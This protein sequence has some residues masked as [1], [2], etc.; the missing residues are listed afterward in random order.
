MILKW[1]EW[2]KNWI[3]NFV[4]DRMPDGFQ[5]NRDTDKV[6]LI[7]R[8]YFDLIGLPPTPEEV[9]SFVND[10]SKD[11]FEKVVDHL[12][13]SPHFGERIAIYWLDLVR[14]A[15]TVG[16]H[17][18]QDHSIT[19]YRDWVIDALNDNMRFDQFTREQLAGDLLDN[20]TIDQK[21]ASGYNRL[22]QTTHEGGAQAREY[23]AIYAA[24]RVRNVSAVWMGATVGC[25]Q[26][27]DHKYDPY[28]IDDFYK[29]SA[30]F[31]DLDDAQHLSNGTNA[32][33]T[34]RDPEITV[35]SRRD[36]Q[37]VDRLEKE[38]EQ[39]KSR[40]EKSR[41]E[42]V[43]N[44]AEL[45]LEIKKLEQSI[46]EVNARQRKTMISAALKEPRTTRILPRGN[47]LDDSGP[48]VDPAIPGILGSISTKQNRPT[49][50]D[51]ANWLTDSEKGY[52]KLAARVMAN[53]FWYLLTG[54]A[55]S[56]TMDD[57]GG[58]GTPP[59]APDLLDNLAIEFVES[60]WDMKHLIRL[61]VTSRTYR[62]SS[63]ATAEQLKLDSENQWFA[64]AGRYRLPAEVI[65]DNALA[66]SGLLVD[67][68][69]G[70]SAKP[71]QPPGHYRHLNFPPRKYQR[72]TDQQQYRRGVYVHWQR[73]FLHPMLKSLDAPTREECSAERSRSN[74][75]LAALTLLN[76]PSF[77]EAARVFADRILT[78]GGEDFE[79]RLAFACQ[80]TLSR[81]PTNREVK[82][83]TQLF[84]ENKTVFANDLE[85]AKKLTSVG[86]APVSSHDVAELAA[87]TM[88][89]RAIFNL[90]ENITRN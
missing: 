48:I 76:D 23:L 7:R 27:H 1:S 66:V 70:P 79:S 45:E 62:Q 6:T 2:S 39:T 3:D 69:G 26:C 64:R 54:N 56:G 35:L 65:R 24:D 82:I 75:P 5:P 38:L 61:I 55:I 47:W 36:R 31:A 43:N 17:G 37:E 81:N 67:E 59:L 53:R 49:R 34:R 51:L 33:P 4:L 90:N 85:S 86:L 50:L 80:W 16:Y 25:A 44:R 40:L 22:L 41:K 89:A 46:S 20:A 68:I 30:F 28:K 74:T 57:F 87:W 71:F 73:Q 29:L 8:A 32:L 10:E 84:E 88:I 12:L 60:G 18:D 21:I 52:G 78:E 9:H 58:Q 77:I 83:F 63:I 15:D 42:N 11:A 72:D 14:F 19:P 13:E